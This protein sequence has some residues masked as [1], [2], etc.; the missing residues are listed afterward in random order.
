MC[1]CLMPYEPWQDSFAFVVVGTLVFTVIL[2][3]LLVYAM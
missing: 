1:S 2:G 3:L